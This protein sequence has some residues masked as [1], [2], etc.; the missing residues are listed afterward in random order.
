MAMTDRGPDRGGVGMGV[1][2][3]MGGGHRGDVG[4][5]EIGVGGVG[6]GVGHRE[7]GGWGVRG[8]AEPTEQA[9]VSKRNQNC[10]AGIFFFHFS[11]FLTV[12]LLFK[13]RFAV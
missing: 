6:M 9:A 11:S 7:D 12:Y 1:A 5:V 13:C 4:S 2:V 10:Q 8:V 3:G